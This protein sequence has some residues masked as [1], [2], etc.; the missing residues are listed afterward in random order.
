[1]EDGYIGFHNISKRFRRGEI[2][3]SLRDLLPYIAKRLIPGR[4]PATDLEKDEFWAVRDVDFEVRPGSTIGLIG[5]N[6][7]GK[8][9]CLKLMTRILRPTRGQIE[10]RGRIGSLI[11]IS[12]GFHGDLTGRENVFL[13]GS[14]MGM[15][16]AQIRQKF[17]QIVEFSGIGEFLDTPVKR[18]SSGMHA[19]LGFSIAAHLDPD[20]LII[21]EVLAVGDYTFQ[22]R[23]FGRIRDL[24]TS[25]IP[26]VI[27]SHQLDRV[28][29]LCTDVIV[30]DHGAVGFRG[31][32]VDAIGWYLA[33]G[34]AGQED[35]SES[36]SAIRLQSLIVAGDREV[37]SGGRVSLDLQGHVGPDGPG[38]EKIVL[39]VS[40]TATGKGRSA[41]VAGVATDTYGLALPEEGPFRIEIKLN[42]NLRS[43]IYA[44]Q[45]YVVD[46]KTGSDVCPGP[47]AYVQVREDPGFIG[48]V[49]LNPEM[50]LFR[51]E[52]AET[53]APTAGVIPR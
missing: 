34:R 49:Q 3:D 48:T 33:G 43:G 7:S 41:I 21:D 37:D 40:T 25:G 26:V 29:E 19:R 46:R 18:Y 50:R 53:S 12:A 14:I 32:A 20:V 36:A 22:N 47:I 35:G 44:I 42:L 15:S 23:A 38:D 52:S 5:A 4:R 2:H 27:V 10:V 30:L 6:G 51:G 39:R 45:S 1:M 9:T 11:E 31:P 17:D 13:Q 28:A 24:A 8:S 16:L